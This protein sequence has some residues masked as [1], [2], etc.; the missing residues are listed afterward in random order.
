[1]EKSNIV[2][3]YTDIIANIISLARKTIILFKLFGS[4]IKD[5]MVLKIIL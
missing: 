3:A 4:K 5:S 1:M 2:Y